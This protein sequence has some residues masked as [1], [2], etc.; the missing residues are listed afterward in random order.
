MAE[1]KNDED[2]LLYSVQLVGID[3][4]VDIAQCKAKLAAL[5]KAPPTTIDALI[6]A[7]PY[8]VKKGLDFKTATKY[9][10]VLAAIG[11][12][13]RIEQ[14]HLEVDLLELS[15]DSPAPPTILNAL[16]VTATA[17]TIAT[18]PVSEVACDAGLEQRMLRLQ[19]ASASNIKRN[20][21]LNY[22]EELLARPAVLTTYD[23]LTAFRSGMSETALWGRCL[24]YPED[25][26]VRRLLATEDADVLRVASGRLT[27]STVGR[28]FKHLVSPDPQQ[29]TQDMN[30]LVERFSLYE[31]PQLMRVLT[32]CIQNDFTH[33]AL[34]QVRKLLHPAANGGSEELTSTELSGGESQPAG[35]EAE[36][37]R[38]R[39]FPSIGRVLTV[40]VGAAAAGGLVKMEL[41][42]LAL[43]V[44]AVSVIG[45]F[46]H[47]CYSEHEAGRL[48]VFWC[49]ADATLTFVG[50]L[51]ALMLLVI[52][53]FWQSFQMYVFAAAGLVLLWALNHVFI[54]SA[55]TNLTTRGAIVSMLAKASIALL[56][57]I[58]IG[59]WFAHA[60][61]KPDRRP[62]QTDREYDRDVQNHERNV[63]LHGATTAGAIFGAGWIFTRHRSNDVPLPFSEQSTTN[64]LAVGTAA[65]L[66]LV[67]GLFIY[68][69]EVEVAWDRFAMISFIQQPALERSKPTL[70]TVNLPLAVAS[71]DSIATEAGNVAAQPQQQRST[72]SGVPSFA[73][74]ESYASARAKLLAANWQPFHSQQAD[75]CSAD[76]VRCQ[77]RPE[78]ESCSGTGVAACSFLWSRDDVIITVMT[79]GETDPRV[80]SVQSQQAQMD[81]GPSFDCQKAASRIEHIICASTNLA[82]MDRELA[83]VFAAA[84]QDAPNVEEFMRF[85]RAS[86]QEREQT[87][88]DRECLVRWY[89]KRRLQ[90]T[91]AKTPS[92]ALLPNPTS[93]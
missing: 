89:D 49:P 13:S 57:L 74:A 67:L 53:A 2:L 35:G 76:D 68:R 71:A 58:S 90:L 69:Q 72:T 40:V 65:L 61:G 88:F 11:A 64:K 18:A 9:Q 47:W 52:G 70:G 24:F 31:D 39:D 30:L 85:A 84:R 17:P 27:D 34:P 46:L 12:A 50:P 7:L 3:Q 29:A 80:V 62:V 1:Q 81:Q 82:R 23:D 36:A 79:A 15:V 86:W 28:F 21:M 66:V 32:T 48:T 83:V 5:F 73:A 20:F 77:G 6:A 8:V 55:R 16:R 4:G 25:P 87:C 43:L 10:S 60:M 38:I 42:W 91:T 56:S 45:V 22:L 63:A 78:M 75:Q 33:R 26:S 92:T 59:L 93:P 37:P 44:V 51:M 41:A 14:E 19:N 54:F